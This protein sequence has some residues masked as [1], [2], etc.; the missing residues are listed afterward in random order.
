VRG[1][2]SSCGRF[3]L[4][5]TDGLV[6]ALVQSYGAAYGR[7]AIRTR[8]RCGLVVI[9]KRHLWGDGRKVTTTREPPPEG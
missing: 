2:S 7:V 9:H 4:D 3:E 8:T 6:E 5:T 1:E